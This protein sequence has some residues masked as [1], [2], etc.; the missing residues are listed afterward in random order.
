MPHHREFIGKVE[1]NLYVEN[2]VKHKT[3][4][5]RYAKRENQLS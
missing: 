4:S 2:K 3:Q 1:V 5:A